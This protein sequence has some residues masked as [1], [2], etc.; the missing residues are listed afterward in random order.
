MMV[1]NID[2]NPFCHSSASNSTGSYVGAEGDGTN[3]IVDFDT[4]NEIR[5]R[6]GHIVIL[7]NSGEGKSFHRSEKKI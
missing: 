5:R 1:H 2:S 4:L 3:I 6:N 7:G